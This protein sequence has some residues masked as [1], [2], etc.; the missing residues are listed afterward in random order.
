[1]QAL[2]SRGIELKNTSERCTQLDDRDLDRASCWIGLQ[3]REHRPMMAEIF[4]TWSDRIEYWDIQDVDDMHPDLV[5]PQ[6][7]HKVL[8][9]IEKCW[10]DSGV[11]SSSSDASSSSDVSRK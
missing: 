2:K 1:M 10:R 5:L 7:E 8:K 4:P 11:G 9:L 3:E 6:L